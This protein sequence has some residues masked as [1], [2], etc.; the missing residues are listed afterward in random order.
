VI[1]RALSVRETE[2]LVRSLGPEA[3]PAAPR[4]AKAAAASAPAS[5]VHTRAA[6]DRLRFVL[7]TR[8]RIVRRGERGTVEIEFGSE[9]ELNRIYEQLTA[10]IET[11]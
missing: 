9:T 11:S 6:E 1:A 2:A 10:G 5:D 8:V 7:G 4:A 3:G